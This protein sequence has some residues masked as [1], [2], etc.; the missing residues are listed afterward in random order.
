[1]TYRRNSKSY[2]NKTNYNS[3]NGMKKRNFENTNNYYSE[4]VPEQIPFNIDTI[5]D[6][7]KMM[8]VDY[9]LSIV[10]TKWNGVSH[11]RLKHFAV[12]ELGNRFPEFKQQVDRHRN[13]RSNDCFVFTDPRKQQLTPNVN[14]PTAIPYTQ[15]PPL[16]SYTQPPPP[17]TPYTQPH[18]PLTPYTQPHPPLTPY[19]QPPPPTTPYPY[20][21]NNVSELEKK[22]INCFLGKIKKNKK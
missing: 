3:F 11:F 10:N 7:I 13:S 6:D 1:M 14:G 19:T 12:R 4:P 2:S 16:T 17:L 18:P 21:N 9:L 20:K 15:L 22:M 8:S 5:D